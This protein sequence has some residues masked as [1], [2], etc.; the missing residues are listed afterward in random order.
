MF[1]GTH[2]DLKDEL[3]PRSGFIY[4]VIM[5]GLDS[6]FW[7]AISGTVTVVSNK[8]R[9]NA[10]AL[11]S[12]TQFLFGKFEFAVNVPTTPSTGE[13]KKWGLLN[14]SDATAGSAYFE[15][16][17]AVF[18]AVSYDNDGTVETT[19]ITWDSWETAE[20]SFEIQWER[21]WVIF[22]VD[23]TVVA[24]HKT[25]VGTLAQGLYIINADSDNTDVGF[26]K[27]KDTSMYV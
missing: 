3:K 4:D 24:T 15:I 6:S 27:V 16:V 25:S 19:A 10:D 18:N 14:P 1:Q 22:L 8:L 11:G 20:T 7:K 21:G 2:R 9:F 26:I 12:Y 17:G 5:R 13:A 23:G